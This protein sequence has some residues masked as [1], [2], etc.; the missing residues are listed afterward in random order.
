MWEKLILSQKADIN[1][2]IPIYKECIGTP[3]AKFTKDTIVS[4]QVI[5]ETNK[6]KYPFWKGI[7]GV[8]LL[9]G[10][11]A[12]AGI[13]GKKKEYLIAIEWKHNGLYEYDKSLVLLDE[14][15]YKTFIRSMF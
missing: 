7:L 6:N 15:H 13:G 8:V 1:S 11:G 4:Y 12:V 3:R 9:G 10:I 14:R 5:G 2:S